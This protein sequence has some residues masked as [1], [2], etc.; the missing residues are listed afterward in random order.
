MNIENE[1]EKELL[2]AGD[3]G[4]IP[5]LLQ[6]KGITPWSSSTNLIQS[7]Q[8]T[9]FASETDIHSFQVLSQQL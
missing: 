5:A 2:R 4:G 1:I 9:E 8:L 7:V 3:R 6:V